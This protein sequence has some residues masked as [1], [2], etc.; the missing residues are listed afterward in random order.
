MTRFHSKAAVGGALGAA[1]VLVFAAVPVVAATG[2]GGGTGGFTYSHPIVK[3]TAGICTHENPGTYQSGSD[4]TGTLT[5]GA[6]T[7]S[8]A[9]SLRYSYDAYANPTGSYQPVGGAC[10]VPGS[11]PVANGATFI[12]GPSTGVHFSCTFTSGTFA[13]GTGETP[14]NSDI[15]HYTTHLAGMCEFFNGTTSLG[16]SS[17]SLIVTG[18]VD[19]CGTSMPP[20]ACTTIDNQ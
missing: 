18:N 13:R 9:V 4:W 16:K 12:G 2:S 10:L 5:Q 15:C 7:Y 19:N 3:D 1:A 11:G 14:P 8:G 20:D 17:T 6:T